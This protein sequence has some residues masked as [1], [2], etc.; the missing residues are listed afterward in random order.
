MP[1]AIIPASQNSNCPMFK[2]DWQSSSF[3]QVDCQGVGNEEEMEGL[4]VL[5]IRDRR[6]ALFVQRSVKTTHCLSEEKIQLQFWA[7]T[8]FCF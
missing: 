2:D 7:G 5:R 3:I 6:L 1:T 4:R 8:E